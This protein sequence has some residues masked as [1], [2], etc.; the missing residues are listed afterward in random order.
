MPEVDVTYSD[1]TFTKSAP[2]DNNSSAADTTYAEVKLSKQEDTKDLSIHI[3]QKEDVQQPRRD[4]KSKMSPGVLVVLIT[5]VV[6]LAAAASGLVVFYLTH[7][8][9]LQRLNEEIKVLKN[10]LSESTGKPTSPP[11][12]TCPSCPV[13]S[14]DPTSGTT[15]PLLPTSL[16]P[17]TCPPPTCPPP[18]CPPPTCPGPSTYPTTKTTGS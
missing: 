17:P 5:L 6:L 15:E 10:K 8:E 16:V 11:A 18:T 14:S 12:A 4:R 13:T 9:T 7:T 3:K 1:V 2:R